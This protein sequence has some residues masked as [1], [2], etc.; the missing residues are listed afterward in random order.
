MIAVRLTYAEELEAHEIGFIRAKELAATADHE[1]RYDRGLNYHEFIAQLSESVGSEIAV[2]KYFNL[3]D[4]KPTHASFKTEADVGK[5][6][7]VKH[8][9]WKDGHLVVHKSDRIED[10]AIL[11]TNRSPNYYLAGWIPVRNARVD[12]NYRASE[13]N[14]W[15]NQADLRPMEDFLRSQYAMSHL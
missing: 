9:R 4:F 3:T 11:V 7:E 1:S 12:R 2:A 14:Y 15:I 13:N 10:I 8:T 6:I 5:S